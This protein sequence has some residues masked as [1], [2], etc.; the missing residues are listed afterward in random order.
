MPKFNILHITDAHFGQGGMDGRWSAVQAVLF[1]DIEYLL[2]KTGALDLIVFT[3][4]VA[5][6]ADPSE[7]GEASRFL[8]ALSE[9]ILDTGI[10]RFPLFAAV[11]GNHDVQRGS[12]GRLV[13]PALWDNWDNEAEHL[14]F[15]D[16]DDEVRLQ[17]IA[18]F[19]NYK[20]WADAKNSPFVPATISSVGV[21][22]G[23]FAAHVD[24]DSARLGILGVNSSFRHFS[25]KAAPDT[26]TVSPLQVQAAAGGDLQAW[27]S[28]MDFALVLSHHP[29]TWLKNRLDATDAIFG[30][31][32]RVKLH[33]CGHLHEENYTANAL[34][35]AGAHLVHQSPSLFGLENY[36]PNNEGEREHGYALVTVE[37]GDSPGVV[38]WPRRGERTRAGSWAIAADSKFGLPK[39]QEFSNKVPLPTVK[40]A[41]AAPADPTEAVAPLEIGRDEA[42]IASTLAR[43]IE[44]V[45]QGTI[46]VLLGDRLESTAPGSELSFASFRSEVW[47]LANGLEPEDSSYPTDQLMKALEYTH[48]QA[49]KN[50]VSDRL[51][52]PSGASI[53]L[54][55]LIAAGPWADLIYLSPMRDLDQVERAGG[56]DG[57]V[58]SPGV[59]DGTNQ[60]YQLPATRDR[61]VP[62]RLASA[63]PAN[64]TTR[65]RLPFEAGLSTSGSADDWFRHATTALTRS[66]VLFL[67]DSVNSLGF[68]RWIAERSSSSPKY[69]LPAYLVCPT[70][71]AHLAAALDT[72]GVEWIPSTV[73][74]FVNTYMVSSRAEIAEGKKHRAHLFLHGDRGVNLDVSRLL[75]SRPGGS[76]EYLLGRSPQWGDIADNFAVE[77]GMFNTALAQTRSPKHDLLV[78]TGTAG[79]GKTTILMQVA[80]QLA[81]ESARVAWIDPLGATHIPDLL[82]AVDKG[83]YDYVFVDDADTYGSRASSFLRELQGPRGSRRVVIAGA[84]SVQAEILEPTGPRELIE[85]RDLGESDFDLLVEVLRKHRALANKRSLDA[86][87]RSLLKN[88]ATGQLLVGMIQAT[89]GMPFTEKIASEC[90]QLSP[91]SLMIYGGAAIVS[92]EQESISQDQLLELGRASAQQNWAN[93]QRLFEMKMLIPA[94]GLPGSWTVRHRVVAREAVNYLVQRGLIAKVLGRTLKILASAAANVRDRSDPSR[95]TFIRLL[96]HNYIIGLRLQVDEIREI[97][98]SVEEVLQD[99]FHYWLQRGAFEVEKGSPSY[100]MHYLKSALTT[101]G[102][103][104]DFKV[105]TEY[106]IM[107]LRAAGNDTS[108]DSTKLGLSA[109][110]DLLTVIREHGINTPHSITVLAKEG[111]AWLVAADISRT[112]K[113]RL[114]E[115]A[116]TLLKVGLRLADSNREVAATV[117]PGLVALAALR[118]RIEL[119][120]RS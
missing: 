42:S 31:R 20:D 72:H 23:D 62:I 17:S 80:A 15:T 92:A 91:E 9:V 120:G 29:F 8:E 55:S 34:G 94:A 68:W 3:G 44:H 87:V 45:R 33:L 97:Y 104:R 109:I 52:N 65:L 69:R 75:A 14:F 112:E 66:P 84:R 46:S 60:V 101:D 58:M 81:S 32:H 64:G 4:D 59:V 100:A 30:G 63:A 89:S 41:T 21:L 5:N 111:V 39:G 16:P 27:A 116:E 118:E 49:L 106:A 113:S 37:T 115:G 76:K 79:S 74:D 11:P 50:L 77:L 107:R 35:S 51:G 12:L 73:A 70:L 102:G 105:L 86:D 61:L 85:M 40:Q 103:E 78:L 10:D 98:D 7:Y 108:P 67:T 54:A 82:D 26:L 57:E 114:A 93:L 56:E 6:R 119:E 48:T 38:V 24:V 117:P 1:E 25:D 99:D 110:E 28:T 83:A 2:A 53:R 71:P 47:K 36:G 96:N 19:K 18:S 90:A 13:K 88:D 95:R 43:Y 22:P